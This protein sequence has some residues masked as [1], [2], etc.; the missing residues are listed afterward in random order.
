M[1]KHLSID[2]ASP[3][4]KEFLQQLGTE[5]DGCI[6]ELNGRPVVGIVPPWQVE[7]L[8]HDRQE[9]IQLLRHSWNRTHTIPEEEITQV[10]TEEIQNVRRERNQNQA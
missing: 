2:D 9:A 10:V 8:S 5:K 7:K 3:Q 4:V 1:T 6:V